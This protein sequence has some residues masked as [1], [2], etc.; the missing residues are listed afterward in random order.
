MISEVNSSLHTPFLTFARYTSAL[1][2]CPVVYT[3]PPLCNVMKLPFAS[4]FCHTVTF[5]FSASMLNTTLSPGHGAVS[6]SAMN[7]A[8]VCVNAFSSLV[9]ST[10]AQP[11]CCTLVLTY[12]LS[13]TFTD[14]VSAV[15]AD[16]V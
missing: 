15:V 16:G 8:M 6:L 7:P 4:F 10:T 14:N 13:V 11:L 3:S 5:P 1:N 12:R 9:R 2:N